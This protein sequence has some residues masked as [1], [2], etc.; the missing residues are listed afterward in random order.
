MVTHKTFVKKFQCCPLGHDNIELHL[1]PVLL[2]T[3]MV[4]KTPWSFHLYKTQAHAFTTRPSSLM[5]A[6]LLS[7]A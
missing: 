1:S 7:I 2:E 3:V 4:K 5:V 6:L